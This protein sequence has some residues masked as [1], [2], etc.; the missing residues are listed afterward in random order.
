[1]KTAPNCRV[2]VGVPISPG[3]AQGEAFVYRDILDR[4]AVARG[5]RA[6]DVDKECARIAHAIQEVLRD[7]DAAAERVE[8]E[9]D[10]STADIFRA[11]GEMLR[12]VT[13]ANEMV[14]EVRKNLVGAEY[15]VHLI[16]RRW[17]AR[18]RSIE[19]ETFRQRGDDV[20]DIG[21]R[22]LRSLGGALAHPLEEM[23]EKSI[24]VARRLLPSDT[25]YFPRRSVAGIAVEEGGPG[26][27]CALLTRQLGIPGIA[28]VPGL[29]KHVT[30]GDWLLLDGIKGTVTIAPDE[31]ARAD[32]GMRMRENR[33]IGAQ[34]SA[35]AHEPAIT[36]DGVVIPVMANIGHR[37]D[38]DIASQNGADGVGLFRMEVFFLS[39]KMLPTEAELVTG[40]TDAL[41]PFKGKPVSIRLLDI[42]GD[43]TLPYLPLP[44]EPNP[45][46]GR[47]GVR[48][49]LE[50]PELLSLQLRALLRISRH[51]HLQILVPMVTVADDMRKVRAKL[52]RVAAE[53]GFGDIPK[54]GAMVETPAAAV[55]A[56]GIAEVSDF[57]NIGTND[58]TQ[59]TM[60]AG[61]ENPFV[62]QYF[63]DDHPAIM[64]LL[65]HIGREAHGVPVGICGDLA[66]RCDLV[67]D[68]LR[69]GICMLS[70][71]PRLVPQVKE[72]V[73]D[74]IAGL[75]ERRHPTRV[76]GRLPDKGEG[77]SGTM[78]EKVDRGLKRVA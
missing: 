45:F 13:F 47:R 38:A 77:A 32:F 14:T 49:L 60:A 64:R 42:G 8:R 10:V 55:C 16:M 20:I 50:Y 63:M 44:S 35:R 1:M 43:K 17:K 46:L 41:E 54:L 51:C 57:L 3:L 40:I 22:L 67:P 75:D 31:N 21:R 29:L 9:L 28:Q 66:S 4:A 48:F 69:A 70:V 39:R 34:A 58:L 23:P 27:H 26:S 36:K 2:T 52:E 62:C 53:L 37:Q 74:A 61:R 12:D 30:A 33:A 68:L 18:F 56:D 59:Y 71:P 6:D 72:A 65:H 19:N 78:M 5:I 76:I 73:R 25:T 11:H 24:L 15:G 7:L